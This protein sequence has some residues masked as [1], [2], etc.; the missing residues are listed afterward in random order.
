MTVFPPQNVKAVSNQATVWVLQVT[1]DN[2]TDQPIT[3]LVP[4]GRCRTANVI[5]QF[6]LFAVGDS[7]CGFV[8]GA[9]W[10]ASE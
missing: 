5:I 9:V 1:N 4:T 6:R 8:Q 2:Q 10:S 3:E 7:S